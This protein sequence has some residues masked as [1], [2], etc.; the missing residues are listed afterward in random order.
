MGAGPPRLG[1]LDFARNDRL[2]CRIWGKLFGTFVSA[3]PH[4]RSSHPLSQL[5]VASKRRRSSWRTAVFSPSQVE[6]LE[7]EAALLAGGRGYEW[8]LLCL[9][10]VLVLLR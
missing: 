2:L 4:G 3:A 6:Y 9:D 1:F 7:S 5:A 10:E 8:E